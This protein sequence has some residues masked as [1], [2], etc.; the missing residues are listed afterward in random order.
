MNKKPL[1]R[2]NKVSYG[3][4]TTERVDPVTPA[5]DDDDAFQLV[6]ITPDSH[7]RAKRG[8]ARQQ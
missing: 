1:G 8:P 4:Q 3:N 7:F 2:N 6:S 5:D